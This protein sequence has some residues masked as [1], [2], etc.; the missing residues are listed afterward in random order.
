MRIS[1]Q[2]VAN[3]AGRGGEGA[4]VLPTKKDPL[5]CA[6][7]CSTTSE[8]LRP[9][10]SRILVVM[11]ELGEVGDRCMAGGAVVEGPQTLGA[12][13]ERRKDKRTANTWHF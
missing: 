13:A 3:K 8:K 11:R 9:L 5:A 4:R 6:E 7:A 2:L 10:Q 1:G 12:T